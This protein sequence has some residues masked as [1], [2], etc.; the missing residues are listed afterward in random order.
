MAQVLWIQTA[1]P[2]GLPDT[3]M[4]EGVSEIRTG[5]KD[6]LW[7]YLEPQEHTATKGRQACT[8]FTVDRSSAPH[9]PRHNVAM[10]P[11]L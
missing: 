10:T 9:N 2:R 5:S 3:K 1:V 6:D 4:D 7:T 8:S 11:T